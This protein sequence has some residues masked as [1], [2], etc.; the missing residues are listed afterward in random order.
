M[1]GITA[2]AGIIMIMPAAVATI[3]SMPIITAAAVSA[4]HK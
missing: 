2:I 1:K 4:Q 3:I